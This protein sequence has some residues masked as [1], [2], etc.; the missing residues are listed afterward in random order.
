[1]Y[2]HLYQFLTS[3]ESSG[4][5]CHF[6]NRQHLVIVLMFQPFNINKVWWHDP[7]VARAES[8][9]F[10][11]AR[12]RR[13]SPGTMRPRNTLR[14]AVRI[15]W[16][17]RRVGEGTPGLSNA[18]NFGLIHLYLS[19]KCVSHF[20]EKRRC[21]WKFRTVNLYKS[22]CWGVSRGIRLST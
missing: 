1:M 8:S 13:H 9:L 3:L 12:R 6:L 5:P 10:T 2:W 19:M 17:W 14:C 21:L 4:M 7:Q 22:W 11:C 15:I 20:G 18:T 16:S